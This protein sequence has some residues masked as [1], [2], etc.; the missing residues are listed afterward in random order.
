MPSSYPLLEP[1]SRL[2]LSKGHLALAVMAK[3]PQTGAVKTRLSPPL[4]LNEASLLHTCFLRD[5][6]SSIAA[7]LSEHIHGYVA[8]TPLGCEGVFNGLLPDQFRLLP[9]RGAHL[10]ERLV[11]AAE[12]FLAAGYEG[13]CLINADSP[14]LPSVL[15]ERAV[16]ALLRPGDRMVLGKAVDGGYYAIGLKKSHRRLFE[17][18]PWSTDAVFDETIERARELGL[19]MELLPPWYDVDDAKSLGW[20]CGELFGGNGRHNPENLA[21]YSAPHTRKYLGSLIEKRGLQALGGPA[22]GVT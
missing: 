15:L 9:Q 11:N 16:N 1:G 8:Y 21:P 19:E 7:L 13:S 14:T 18:I 20:L 6:T 3:A 22:V 10:G 17:D 4:E 2:P 12:D 5:I